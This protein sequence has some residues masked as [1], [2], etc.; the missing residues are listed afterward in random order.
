MGRIGQFNLLYLRVKKKEKK[1][2]LV[3]NSLST[4]PW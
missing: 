4:V 1:V 3:L 2:G